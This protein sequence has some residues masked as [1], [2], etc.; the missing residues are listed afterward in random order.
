MCDGY[1]VAICLPCSDFL[2]WL[3]LYSSSLFYFMEMER[4]MQNSLKH[5]IHYSS[6]KMMSVYPFAVSEFSGSFFSIRI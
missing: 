6:S 2:P 5:F 4:F 3:V 1:S